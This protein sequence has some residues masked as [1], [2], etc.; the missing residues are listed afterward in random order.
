MQ[1]LR[2]KVKWGEFLHTPFKGVKSDCSKGRTC[3][4]TMQMGVESS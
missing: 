2:A 4:I 1:G 3:C